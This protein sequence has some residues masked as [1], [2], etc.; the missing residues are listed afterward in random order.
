VPDRVT[1]V[2]LLFFAIAAACFALGLW[3]L[4]DSADLLAVL[5]LA[6]GAL[7]L[8]GVSQAARASEGGQR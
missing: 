8:R 7:S 2:L 4:G 3:A 5:L 1:G 6:L